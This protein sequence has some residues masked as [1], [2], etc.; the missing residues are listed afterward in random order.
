LRQINEV[1]E[2][3]IAFGHQRMYPEI[4]TWIDLKALP[5]GGAR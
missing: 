3:A 2:I 5:Q 4:A 1:K